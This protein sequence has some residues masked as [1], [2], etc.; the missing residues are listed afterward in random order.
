MKVQ[1]ETKQ[2]RAPR[3]CVVGS[4]WECSRRESPLRN[5]ILADCYR[6]L[7]APVEGQHL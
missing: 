3:R 5:D 2:D 4:R 6:A 7:V 1:Y